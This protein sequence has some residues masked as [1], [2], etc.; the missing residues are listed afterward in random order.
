LTT[1]TSRD[2]AVLM[3]QG[4]IPPLRRVVFSLAGIERIH[5]IGCARSGTTMLHL[6]MA[7][8]ANVTLSE[9][10][11]DVRYPF[12]LK[13][14][15]LALQLGWRP[16]RK[17]FVT[18]RDAGWL[19]P[20]CIEPLIEE[21]RRENIGLIHMVRDPRDIMLSQYDG[22][23]RAPNRPYVTDEHWYTSIMAADRIFKALDGHKRK[24]VVRYEDVVLDP[25]TTQQRFAATFGLEPNANALSIDRVKDNFQRLGIRFRGDELKALNGLRNMDARSIGRWRNVEPRP[26]LDTMQP[27]IRARLEAFCAEHGYV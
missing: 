17:F 25:L 24:L 11:S 2:D 10:E 21:T 3:S 13:R 9:S 15:G 6:A 8:F 7:C 27:A 4:I 1:T 14:I 23:V 26:S 5:I 19:T 20:P 22:S 16:G 12:L 18:K